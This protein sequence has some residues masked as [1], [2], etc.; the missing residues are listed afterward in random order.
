MGQRTSKR[1]SDGPVARSAR[2]MVERVEQ[3]PRGLTDLRTGDQDSGA[4]QALIVHPNFSNLAYAAST[5]GG[6]WKTTDLL[7]ATPTWQPLTDLMPML[8]LGA[9]AF[10]PL[11]P[12]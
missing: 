12:S 10:S 7:S 8:S 3:R 1:H 11:D 9:I 5:N 6:V 2:W 4:V